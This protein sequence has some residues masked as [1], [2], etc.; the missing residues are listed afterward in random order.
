[1]RL[2]ARFI[3]DN[4]LATET[5]EESYY[6]AQ[7]IHRQAY[8]SIIVGIFIS[9]LD[10][11]AVNLL[12]PSIADEFKSSE[13]SSI[14][15]INSYQISILVM[16]LPLAAIGDRIGHGKIYQLGLILFTGASLLGSL[17][18]SLEALVATRILQG[19]GAAGIMAVNAALLRMLFPEAMLGRKLA[20]I[21]MVAA[22]GAV[23]GPALASI[24]A[25]YA[26]WP[27]LFALK[28]PIGI[29]A[30]LAG[31]R[32]FPQNSSKSAPFSGTSLFLNIATFAL[33]FVGLSYLTSSLDKNHMILGWAMLGA[34]LPMAFLYVRHQSRENH[35]L[36]PLDLLCNRD[37]SL[38][39]C[40]LTSAYFALTI[41]HIGLPFTLLHTY[42]YT[43]EQASV[44]L[45]AWPVA[46]I[47]ISPVAGRLVGRHSNGVIS[48]IGI[49]IFAVGIFLLALLSA[50][51]TDLGLFCCIFL[52][53]AGFA[54]FHVPNNHTIVTTTPMERSGSGSAM[55]SV[56][57][58]T[59]QCLGAACIALLFTIWPGQDGTAEI[60]GLVAAGGFAIA[61]GLL[62]WLQAHRT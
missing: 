4:S 62:G 13:S 37:F 18:Q 36:L 61:S 48:S 47:L 16:L 49:F 29:M 58:L 31:Y 14:L 27:W 44:M 39:I 40:A 12:L 6:S 35:P 19:I 25:A 26:S 56:S 7:K 28:V 41:V 9:V 57:R 1:M 24:I 11:T 22:I 5:R 20:A 60:I 2:K 54:L 15:I 32:S 50:Q 53:G 3:T 45:L 38:S 17:A 59:G 43:A 10:A 34:S 30:I 42:R 33:F 51:P 46:F 52:C 55:L 8:F 23:S 21:S